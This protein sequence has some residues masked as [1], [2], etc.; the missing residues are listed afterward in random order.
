M[1]SNS[2][3]E[4][5]KLCISTERFSVPPN[6]PELLN[7]DIEED[8]NVTY[9]CLD[10]KTF[11]K[12]INEA[13]EQSIFWRKNIFSLPR[14][15]SAKKFINLLGY[16]ID[17][18]NK[19]TPF[20]EV[21]LKVF[22][23]LPNLMCQKPTKF[24][25]AVDHR[26]SLERRMKLWEDGHIKELVKEGRLIQRR[27]TSAVRRPEDIAKLFVRFMLHGKVNS[28]LRL[29]E[30]SGNAGV[31]PM[32]EENLLSLK[33]KHPP[34]AASIEGSLFNGPIREIEPTYFDVIDTDMIDRAIRK[35][36]GSAG[37]SNM[38]S[39]FFKEL[40]HKSFRKEGDGLKQ[41]IA[42]L[43]RKLAVDNID[44][45]HLQSFVAC[46]LIPL[47]KN[48]GVR[49]IGIGETIR[50][51]V[52]KVISWVV[53]QDV[54]DVV[55][56]LQVAAGMRAGSESAIHA[57]RE[58]FEDGDED[59]AIILVDAQNAFNS[60]NRYVALHNVRV[61]CPEIA[62]FLI[63]TYR[64]P[65]RLFIRGD[66][67]PDE[68]IGSVEGT[69][70]GDNLSMLF[71]SLGTLPIVWK[72]QQLNKDLGLNVRQ[73]WLAD[74]ATGIGK[75]NHLR[76]WWD[77]LVESGLHYGYYVN[78]QKTWIIVK[79]E[80]T[81]KEAKRIFGG[82]DLKFTMEGKRHLGACLGSEEFKS[83]YC[84]DKVSE[85]CKEVE[86]LSGI[87]QY[88]P[89]AAY[90]AYVHGYQHKYTYFMRT[91]P[92]FEKFLAPLDDL[93]TYGFLPTLFGSSLSSSEREIMA[94]PTRFGGLGISNLQD[95]APREY[96]ASRLITSENVSAIKQ[97]KM[98]VPPFN[99]YAVAQVKG[100]LAEL[101]K[102]RLSSVK[103][104][105]SITLRRALEL[106][107]EKGASNWLTTLPL[108][109]QGFVLNRNEFTDA[110]NLRYY[111]ELRGLPSKCPCGQQFGL[112]HALNCKTG[113]FVHIRHDSL[114]D[115]NAKLLGKV[116]KDVEKEPSLIPI[117]NSHS[118][119]NSNGNNTSD[120]ARVDIRA[121]GFWRNGQSAF[122]D[123]RVT[124][125]FSASA[126]KTPISKIFDNHEREK[127]REYNW[128]IMNVDNGTFTPLVY[129][130]SGNVG[131]ECGKFYNHLC[132]KIANKNNE[133]YSDVISWVRTKVSFMCLKNALMCLRG[134]RSVKK[135]NN[136]GYVS[137]DFKYDVMQCRI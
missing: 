83:E 8:V 97:Q 128:R 70:Q 14:G 115:L 118:T 12:N 112:T 61:I 59:E 32:T 36:S 130:I 34:P 113:G 53:K 62:P 73:A 124:N 17:Q 18:F 40:G 6:L 35:T 38:D 31:L 133:K 64:K 91:I 136:L 135:D 10:I 68:E 50:R 56:P 22:M 96:S 75:L 134:T 23:V 72:L 98:S 92:E 67:S 3:S 15:D 13:Y 28:A 51:I 111:R 79:N 49:P 63:N 76:V 19:D 1:T 107:E 2:T 84:T 116:H 88:H 126:I 46:R 30:Q 132:T 86:L 101:Y 99:E 102:Q 60:L 87:A 48:P 57:M 103:H 125:P 117:N 114:R 85:W 127:K 82:T 108:T 129:T 29:L 119:D 93:I 131:L 47:N 16:W 7:N 110:L 77:K 123:V 9:N 104:H 45:G 21:A 66:K 5:V 24:S 100:N 65:S 95:R 71:Y 90:S 27:L 39:Q 43:A 81:L 137:D 55:G 44:P 20:A 94:L 121:R 4:A 41:H 26:K 109:D 122:F 69:T 25:K 105:A 80:A 74:D 42:F 89:H 58:M 33:E 37:P 52:G 54:M 120:G 106:G 11:V 78:A